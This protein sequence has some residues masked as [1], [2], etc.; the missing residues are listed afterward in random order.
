MNLFSVRAGLDIPFLF[1]ILVLVSI[2]LVMLFSSSYAYAYHNYDGDSF[3]FIKRQ[4]IFAVL[5]IAGMI[6]ISYFDYHHFHK[7][8]IPI[9]IISWLLLGVVLVLPAVQGV[10]RWINL[11]PVSFQ[12]SEIAK[13]ALILWFAHFVSVNFRKMN[14]FK[15]GVLPH[16]F[17]LAVTVGLVFI[18]PH[19]SAS[20]ILILIAEEP[21]QKEEEEW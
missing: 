9:L 12:P 6:A 7:L 8:T 5:G 11:G 18:E 13:F 2:G 15:V 20:I 1:I 17:I 3:Y 14:T 4:A 21:V 19:V 16:L 10:H